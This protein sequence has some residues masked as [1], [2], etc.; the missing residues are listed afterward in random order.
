MA[1]SHRYGRYVINTRCTL[2]HRAYRIG[3]F[4]KTPMCTGYMYF[5]MYGLHKF[6]RH[7]YLVQSIMNVWSDLIEFAEILYGQ[8]YITFVTKKVGGGLGEVSS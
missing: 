4:C 6:T 7:D 1:A 8:I 2:I 3:T 5:V